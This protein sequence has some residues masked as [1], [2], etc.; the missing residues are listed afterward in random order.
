[1]NPGQMNIIGEFYI[2]VC[3]H[4]SGNEFPIVSATSENPGLPQPL[5][6]PTKDFAMMHYQNAKAVADRAQMSLQL[7][8]FEGRRAVNFTAPA[9]TSEA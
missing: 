6:G 9:T 8:R 3:V 4:S 7:V 5:G 1:M 2:W